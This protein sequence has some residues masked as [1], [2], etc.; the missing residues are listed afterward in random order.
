MKK[1]VLSIILAIVLI[2]TAL[3]TVSC[4]GKAPKLEDV[5]E[6]FI[7]L[8]ENSKEINTLYFGSGLPVYERDTLLSNKKG[9]YYDDKYTTYERVMENSRY[10]TIN[11]IKER[12]ERIYSTEYLK[13]M[14][15]TAFE[16]VMTGSSSA[17]IRFYESE[18]WLYQNLYAT[19]FELSE[20]IYDYSSMK[21]VKPSNGEYVN[22]TIDT[23]TL[24][25]KTVKN[26]SLTFV[27]ERGDWYLDS[28]TY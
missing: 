10:L 22:I 14:Y 1:A 26:I 2:I 3:C 18:N 4:S 17:Y 24:E 6:R 15:E 8:I 13:A 19:D 27:Y 25:D 20:R 21:I 11:E 23:Y 28:P 16:G 12:S 5:K 9:V 7:Y